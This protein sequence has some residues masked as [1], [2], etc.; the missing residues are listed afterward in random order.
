M[1]E[2]VVPDLR[3]IP[4]RAA[5]G[6]RGTRAVTGELAVMTQVLDPYGDWVYEDAPLQ[7][8]GRGRV[9]FVPIG[10]GA[11]RRVIDRPLPTGEGL[12]FEG[13]PDG[14]WSVDVFE[15]GFESR[16]VRTWGD[17]SFYTTLYRGTEV[18]LDVRLPD[19]TQPEHAFVSFVNRE[20][21]ESWRLDPPTAARHALREMQAWARL[22]DWEFSHWALS[23]PRIGVEVGRDGVPSDVLVF[24]EPRGA[25][26]YDATQP[27]RYV[28]SF[29]RVEA[30]R[31]AP[32]LVQLEETAHLAVEVDV[33]DALVRESSADVSG[34][35]RVVLGGVDSAEFLTSIEGSWFDAPRGPDFFTHP[36]FDFFTRSVVG[37]GSYM[38]T[39]LT[40]GRW[41]IGACW[42][43]EC[44]P[45]TQDVDIALGWNT[46]R[47]SLGQPATD[48]F[49][50]VRF[51]CHPG[52][53][54]PAHTQ[55]EFVLVAGDPPRVTE[56]GVE[57]AHGSSGELWLPR[58]ELL[59]HARSEDRAQP[60]HMVALFRDR[61][62]GR[63]GF[64]SAP[65][66]PTMTALDFTEVPGAR[67]IARAR[68]GPSSTPD[69]TLR[70]TLLASSDARARWVV[71]ADPEALST[72]AW[73][74]DLHGGVGSTVLP[75]LWRIE[76]ALQSAPLVAPPSQVVQ[77]DADG[78][79]TEVEFVFPE[80]YS[81]RVHAPGLAPGERL[82]LRRAADS[83]DA[84]AARSPMLAAT[85]DDGRRVEFLDVPPGHY[86]VCLGT[87]AAPLRVVVPSGEVLY[88]PRRADAF[89][90]RLAA[91]SDGSSGA[92]ARAG[93]RTGDV[94]LA[95]D[96][97]EVRRFE[98]LEALLDAIAEGTV[99]ARVR[100][101]LRALEV[102]L[103]PMPDPADPW[104]T[105]DADFVPAW[106]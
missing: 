39:Y 64:V 17:G 103:G 31:L 37:D 29:V 68:G 99:V 69:Y 77:V 75:G 80:R 98:D 51:A 91:L 74:Q 24:A 65:L 49:V 21:V 36:E 84:A 63:L 78:D 71:A 73:K 86:E 19:G 25:E 18:T 57:W 5:P 85:L 52:R 59:E 11:E 1:A 12:T 94:L 32:A 55:L 89:E 58:E 102:S 9:R 3:A 10:R 22:D 100:R 105:F 66:Q 72:F 81:V 47:I 15:P 50:A 2:L 83:P 56:R 13:L 38:A 97:R 90:V 33:P 20:Y 43:A 27:C 28:S 95:F 14:D 48:G 4:Q 7:A 46:A 26:R 70:M 42:E 92:F 87:A 54:A 45:A 53:A 96:A 93:F 82:R 106:R 34:V 62:G 60:L 16:C 101:G 6:S 40:P 8:T 30:G 44:C 61:R 23:D 41:A 79:V 35:R 88:E 76:A 67:L 104:A